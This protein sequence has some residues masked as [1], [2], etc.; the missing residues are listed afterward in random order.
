MYWTLT[1]AWAVSYTADVGIGGI[2]HSST[3]IGQAHVEEIVVLTTLGMT[4]CARRCE[5]TKPCQDSMKTSACKTSALST[6][7]C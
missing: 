4:S 2:L 6:S 5:S 3:S 7:V 1:I